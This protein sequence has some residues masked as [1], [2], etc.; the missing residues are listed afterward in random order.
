VNVR[1]GHAPHDHHAPLYIAAT[2]GKYFNNVCGV[3]LETME[4]KRLYRLYKNNKYIANIEIDSGTG[5]IQLIRKLDE[6]ILDVSFGGV[7]AMISMI[8]KGSKIKIISPVMTEG[9]AFVVEKD[10]PVSNWSG[11]VN[12]VRARKEPFRVGYKV[13]V[14]VQNLIFETALNTEKLSYSTDMSANDVDIIIMNMHGP[15]NLLP[16]LKAGV[17][18][19]YVVMQPYPALAEF[20]GSAKVI[21]QL[22]DLPPEGRWKDHPCC[23]LAAGE[24]FIAANQEVLDAL[25]KLFGAAGKYIKEF[26]AESAQITSEWLLTPLSVEQKSLPTIKFV[27]DYS[28]E[29]NSG[30]D[31]WIRTLVS[32]RKMTGEVEKA[33]GS[34]QAGDL[35][36]DNRFMKSRGVNVD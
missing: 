31:F 18:D 36:Y 3:Y 6:K 23:A 20:S 33:Y 7:P 13:A 4:S 10:V 32:S 24:D 15:K 27:E 22:S 16:S 30:I 9:A 1:L 5:G 12:Y 26:P 8:D 2:K 21:S 35:I 17:I 19:G 29:W 11:F 34:G 25:V 28:S 14:S